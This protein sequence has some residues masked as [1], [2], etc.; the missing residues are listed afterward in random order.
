MFDADWLTGSYCEMGAESFWN[1]SV[2]ANAT[3][4]SLIRLSYGD[5]WEA[6]ASIPADCWNDTLLQ[7]K[8]RTSN[9][10]SPFYSCW[11]YTSSDWASLY[12]DGDTS[13]SWVIEEAVWWDMSL[14]LSPN[15]APSIILI[16]PD[17][18]DTN[19]PLMP[20]L[21][22]TINDTDSE[23]LN[24]TFYNASDNSIICE[25]LGETAN[26]TLSCNWTDATKNSWH[27]DWYANVTD[28]TN[29]TQSETFGFET[30]METPPT[31]TTT[32]PTTTTT[33]IPTTTTTITAPTG[34]ITATTTST[35]YVITIGFVM[36]CF[37][38][39]FIALKKKFLR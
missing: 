2:P 12:H 39:I 11:N 27:Y 35:I 4:T 8:V 34:D 31:T 14:P 1:Y 22:A 17:D 9:E 28:G 38:A 18:N 32:T 6:N 24:I 23:F 26:T 25:Y 13:S 20:N 3:G 15:E 7:F 10:Y 5:W 16:A 37:L 33:T 36:M 21:T 19:I 29:T 30:I